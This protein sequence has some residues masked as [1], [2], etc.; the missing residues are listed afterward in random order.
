MYS[1]IIFDNKLIVLFLLTVFAIY[2]KDYLPEEEIVRCITIIFT[3][4]IEN[5]MRDIDI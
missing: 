2:M 4:N 1:G 5:D 3:F